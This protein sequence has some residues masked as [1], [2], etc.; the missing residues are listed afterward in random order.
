[1]T[2]FAQGE[3][4]LKHPEKYIGRHQPIYRSGWE[5][6][7]MQFLDNHASILK[8]ASE[9]FAVPYLN[10]VTGKRANYYPDFFIVYEDRDRRQRSEIVEIKPRRQSLIESKMSSRDAATVAVN[11]AKWRSATA[12]C[13][14]NGWHFRV[15]T[16]NEIFARSRGK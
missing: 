3:F 9:P 12:L 13:K 10:P 2:K 8:W 11:H 16:E 4:V 14:A 15:V 1:M 6:A 7:M 5:M